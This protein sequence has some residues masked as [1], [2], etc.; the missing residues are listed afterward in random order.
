MKIEIIDGIGVL[1]P[2]P[3]GDHLVH[4]I[5]EEGR[6]SALFSLVE[7]GIRV[8][9]MPGDG[10]PNYHFDLPIDIVERIHGLIQCEACKKDG[11]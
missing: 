10:L 11:R 7:H 1:K 6:G 8:E 3:L 4:A 9:I 2:Q 5:L